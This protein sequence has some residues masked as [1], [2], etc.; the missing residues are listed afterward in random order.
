VMMVESGNL[1]MGIIPE[2]DVEVVSE[3]L[4]AGDLLIM[5]SDG[6]Y[7]GVKNIENPEFWMKRKI[8]EL[9]T[10]KPQEIADLIM[11]EVIRTEYGRIDDD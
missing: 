3:Q 2:F 6:I 1:P 7:E 5:M 11:E 10:D 8:R 4:K 9:D